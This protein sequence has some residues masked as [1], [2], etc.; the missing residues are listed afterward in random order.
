MTLDDLT[1]LIESATPDQRQRF[2]QALAELPLVRCNRDA[3]QRLL[4]SGPAAPTEEHDSDLHCRELPPEDIGKTI[5][6]DCSAGS[7]KD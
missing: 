7:A 6:L 4:G 1:D 2:A 3:F 5:W